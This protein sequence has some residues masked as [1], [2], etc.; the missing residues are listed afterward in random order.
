MV[1]VLPKNTFQEYTLDANAET[2][3]LVGDV[4]TVSY[5]LKYNLA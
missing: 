5:F 1:S 2:D 4:R 3:F